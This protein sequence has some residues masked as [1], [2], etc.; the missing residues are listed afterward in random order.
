MT[1][2][3]TAHEWECAS[4]T[5]EHLFLICAVCGAKLTERGPPDWKA[6]FYSPCPGRTG[7]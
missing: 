5:R 7:Q 6:A 4:M 3:T 2:T 1:T